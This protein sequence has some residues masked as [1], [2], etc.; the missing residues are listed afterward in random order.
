MSPIPLDMLVLMSRAAISRAN[1]LTLLTN[2]INNMG[3]P[4][5]LEAPSAVPDPRFQR[6]VEIS[7]ELDQAGVIQ[8]VED[9]RKEVQF[10]ILIT[11][12]SPA[13]SEKVR[14][15]LALLGLP[16]PVEES[17]NMILPVYF[18]VKGE[19]S[20]GIAISTRSTFDL[21]EILRAAVE[22]PQEHAGAGGGGTQLSAAR[23]GREEHSHSCFREQAQAGGVGR[24]A[25]WI[26]VLYR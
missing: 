4:D 19:R 18:G 8:F 3:N 10:N 12:Y 23:T 22:I 14:A 11:G 15:Y 25:P 21:I 2:R 17:K 1:H 13:F 7:E 6:F 16:M 5:F 9:P 24:K 26:L 20:G